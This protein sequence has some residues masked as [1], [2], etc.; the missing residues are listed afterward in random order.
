MPAQSTGTE[1][2]VLR[3]KPSELNLTLGATE[4]LRTEVVDVGGRPAK[5]EVLFFSLDRRG[6]SVDKSGKVTALRTGSFRVIARLVGAANGSRV[7]IPVRVVH[8]KPAAIVLRSAPQRVFADTIVELDA[9]IIG[10]D[11]RTRPDLTVDFRSSDPKIVEIDDLRRIVARSAGTC[12]IIASGS[13][14]EQRH[15]LVVVANPVRT[16]TVTPNVK[17]ART[18][19]V[20]H[21]A[22]ATADSA[23]KRIDDVPVQLAVQ[24]KPTDHRGPGASGQIEPD[25]RFVAETPGVY[26][27]IA[28]CGKL[29]ASATVRITPRNVQQQLV[30]VGHGEVFHVHTSDLWVWEGVD[31]RDYAVTGT[32][33]ADGEAYFWDVTDPRRIERIATVKVDARTVN[34]VKVSKDGRICVISREGASNRKNGIIVL[35]VSNPRSPK[36]LSKFTDNLTGGVHNLFID[37]GFVYALSAG[38][39]YDVIDIHD[40]SAP[41]RVSN[42]ELKSPGHAIHDVWIANGIAFSSNWRDGIQL[43][44]VGNGIR[45]GSPQKPVQ[46]ASYAYPSGWNHAAFPFR[47]ATT[48]R[49]YVIA[50][51]EAFPYGL[52]I[53]NR[54]TYPRGW[55]HFIDFTDLDKPREVARYEVPEAG[56]HNLWVEGDVL[57]AAYY[58]AG[59]RVVDISGE[60]LGDLY[61]QGREI[62]WFLPTHHKAKVPNAPMTWGPQP[63][64]GRIFFSDWNSGLWCVE[65]APQRGRRR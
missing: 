7:V 17:Q 18:G 37:S 49:F 16:L 11:G 65:L 63:H 29:A 24:A 57:Y 28:A 9:A 58:N 25:G 47:S 62:A 52:S 27:V 42:F 30:K 60:L 5:G 34:D 33:G 20:V 2:L 21:F 13:G 35:D 64:K 4:T 14:L 26:T 59:V 48:K 38:R 31:G 10:E 54:P 44:D 45:G 1:D 22:V 40:P 55:F 32:W 39:R 23:G 12:A 6:V 56:T 51:D 3:V 19:D 50:G 15:Q 41:V 53:E 61:R 43:V 8:A 36:M 46:F